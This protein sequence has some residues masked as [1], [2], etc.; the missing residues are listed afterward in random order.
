MSQA[1]IVVLEDEPD[2]L[3][4]IVYNL[5]REGFKVTSSGRG[6]EGLRIVQRQRPDLVLLDLMLPGLDG[7]ELCRRLKASPETRS[8]PIIVVSAKGEESDVVLGLGIGA[9]DYICKPF[10]P[11]EL[12]ARVK[13][14]LRRG[15]NLVE[16]RAEE[17][18]SQ[19]PIQIDL[20]RHEL[21]CDG[22]LV[23]LT[24]TEFRLLH[25]LVAN[26]GRVFSR[27]SLL[28]KTMGESAFLV[29]RNVDV[30][31]RSIRKK[32]GDQR[33]LIETVRG[34]GYRFADNGVG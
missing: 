32:L 29:D 14:C 12:V 9:D 10:S 17:R 28:R 30:H 6:D 34:V 21:R 3:D 16:A 4:V 7:L 31:V 19:G 25:L 26:P 20:G 27:E 15:E 11:R 8:M 22:L 1:S 2:I 5:E 33:G 18:L 24:A 23:P 13:A